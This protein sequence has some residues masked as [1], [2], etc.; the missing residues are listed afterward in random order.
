MTARSVVFP[1][2][3]LF[4]SVFGGLWL[5]EIWASLCHSTH[6]FHLPTGFR[7]FWLERTSVVP[8]TFSSRSDFLVLARLELWL[9]KRN[10]KKYTRVIEICY[11]N[12][13]K[14]DILPVPGKGQIGYMEWSARRQ[15]GF[16]CQ[17]CARTLLVRLSACALEQ[18]ISL[19]IY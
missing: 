1:C 14:L 8:F 12:R 2:C 19:I 4:R 9:W 7:T 3:P 13:L 5:D 18:S 6:A 15:R 11:G 10:I 16:H 17:G